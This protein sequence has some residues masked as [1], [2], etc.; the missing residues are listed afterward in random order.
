FLFFHAEETDTTDLNHRTSRVI[1][2]KFSIGIAALS[3][4]I[5]WFALILFAPQFIYTIITPK[6]NLEAENIAGVT[7][8][9]KIIDYSKEDFSQDHHNP[10]T[11]YFLNGVRVTSDTSGKFKSIDITHNTSKSVKTSRGITV[12]DS[13]EKVKAAYGEN[14]Y[15]RH[16]QGAGIIVY[17]DKRSFMEFWHWNDIV[18]EIRYGSY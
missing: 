18:Q 16:E 6:T 11:Y 9:K 5:I 17:V 10:N 2:K 13:L 1:Q 14:F 3:L 12:G 4:V 15:R 8:S 7:L